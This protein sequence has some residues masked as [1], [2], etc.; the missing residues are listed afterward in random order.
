M[1]IVLDANI[2]ISSF[3]WGGNPRTIFER[4]IA[5]TDELFVTKEIL[6]EIE[7]VME[8]PKF[9]AD[10]D[11]IQYYINSIEE[12]GT[13][14]TPNERIKKEY[15]NIKIVTAKDYLAIVKYPAQGAPASPANI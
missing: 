13:K 11:D 1:K 9:H 7:D 4:I 5:G 2:F 3:F 14:I 15:D 8:R 10:N 12:I 6:N